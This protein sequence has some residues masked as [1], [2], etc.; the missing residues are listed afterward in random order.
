MMGVLLTVRQFIF[1]KT[2]IFVARIASNISYQINGRVKHPQNK[3]H[4]GNEPELHKQNQ[5]WRRKI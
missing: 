3:Q 4:V 5:I 1:K 2:G